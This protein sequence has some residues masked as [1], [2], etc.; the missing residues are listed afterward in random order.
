[1][2]RNDKA[3]LKSSSRMRQVS[4][5]NRNCAQPS[6]SP[7]NYSLQNYKAHVTRSGEKANSLLKNHV[8][9]GGVVVVR[10]GVHDRTSAVYI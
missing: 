7:C 1:M 10:L 8:D 6:A 2:M 9:I 5:H 4:T 3:G